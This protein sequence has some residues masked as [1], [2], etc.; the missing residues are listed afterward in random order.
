MIGGWVMV[1]GRVIV[2][3]KCLVSTIKTRYPTQ[4]TNTE[5]SMTHLQQTIKAVIR[6]G[7]ASGYVAEC[8]EVAVVTQ[9]QT[10]DETVANL[11]DAVALHLEGEEPAT[12]GLRERPTLLITLEVDPTYAQ[13]S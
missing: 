13:A 1:A 5:G 11:K 3:L 10:I 4:A 12:F 6:H 9:G 7:D 8:I 2:S